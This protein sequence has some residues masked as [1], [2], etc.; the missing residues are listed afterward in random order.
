MGAAAEPESLTAAWRLVDEGSGVAGF[1]LD[2][3]M[4]WSLA[5]RAAAQALPDADARLAGERARDGSD[6]GQRA[7]ETAAV[8]RPDPDVKAVAWTRFR[9]D[10]D[11]SLHIVRSAM[12]GFWANRD[13]WL[14][15]PALL[16]E[17]VTRFFAEIRG[18]FEGRDKDFATSFFHQLYPSQI[19]T[20]DTISRTQAVLNSLTEGEVLLR[21]SLREALDEAQRAQA[22]RAFAAPLAVE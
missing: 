5:I 10:R 8:A 20:E 16:S 22:C 12:G 18:I 21:R 7:L 13:W 3:D 14:E 15:N 1:E 11:S 4:R 17:Y 2:Q 19:P 6:R 9:E